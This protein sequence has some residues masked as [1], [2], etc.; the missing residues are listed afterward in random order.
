MCW[1]CIGGVSVVYWLCLCGV[2]ET[3]SCG[4]ASAIFLW[5]GVVYVS[6]VGVCLFV[7]C[8]WVFVGVLVI[9]ELL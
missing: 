6:V 1:R 9:C 2:L 3:I 5:C 4:G 7:L 8:W